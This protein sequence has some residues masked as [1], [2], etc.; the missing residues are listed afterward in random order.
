MFLRKIKGKMKVSART[1]SK[2]LI[3]EAVKRVVWAEKQLVSD[4]YHPEKRRLTEKRARSP[5]SG[6]W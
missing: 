6:M 5:V 4:M 2:T 3:L 1:T